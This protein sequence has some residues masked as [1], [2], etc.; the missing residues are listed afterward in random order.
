MA[1][2]YPGPIEIVDFFV[3]RGFGVVLVQFSFQ[4]IRLALE[5]LQGHLNSEVNTL[6]HP[7]WE[8]S[9]ESLN[10]RNDALSGKG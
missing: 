5:L 10:T 7:S 1:K 9:Y 4:R 8:Y 3:R 2:P 6:R